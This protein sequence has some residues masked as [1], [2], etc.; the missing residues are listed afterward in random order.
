MSKEFRQTKRAFK[1]EGYSRQEA[2]RMAT[3]KLNGGGAET[4]IIYKTGGLIP[5]KTG[6]LVPTSKKRTS[7]RAKTT[8]GGYGNGI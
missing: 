6:G 7:K 4:E 3:E 8:N 1:K 2:K 5:Y